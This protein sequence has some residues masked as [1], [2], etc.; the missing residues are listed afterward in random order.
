MLKR[1]MI[2][3]KE[4]RLVF[5][6]ELVRLI[7]YID[8]DLPIPETKLKV[9]TYVPI[10]AQGYDVP[11]Y[12][13]EVELKTEYTERYIIDKKVIYADIDEETEEVF[14]YIDDKEYYYE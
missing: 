10:Y 1:I 13:S 2:D 14:F 7:P 4:M 6:D 3:Q 11:Q 9:E 5:D 12:I 8:Y